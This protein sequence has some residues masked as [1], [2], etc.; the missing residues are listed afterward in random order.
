MYRRCDRL[1]G[2][3]TLGSV[4][5]QSVFFSLSSQYDEVELVC[6]VDL[7]CFVYL[8]SFVQLKNQTDRTNQTNQIQHPAIG[9]Y[10]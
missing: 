10:W 6:L 3:L 7:V 9:G 4:I 8:G 2:E 5:F 1:R